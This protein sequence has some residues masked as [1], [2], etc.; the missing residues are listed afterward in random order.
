MQHARVEW[1]NETTGEWDESMTLRVFA[2][3][4]PCS[5][6]YARIRV[7]VNGRVINTSLQQHFRYRNAASSVLYHYIIAK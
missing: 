3:I 1:A 2:H 7:Q 5:D 4:H 6:E